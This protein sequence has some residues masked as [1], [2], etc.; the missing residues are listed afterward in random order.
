MFEYSE[1][2]HTVKLC[3]GADS[4]TVHLFGA[5]VISWVCGDQE[6]LFLSTKS[7]FD[8]SKAIRGGIPVVFP[9]FGPWECGPQHGFARIS[10][11][12]HTTKPEHN[13]NSLIFELEDNEETRKMWNFKFKLQYT[14]SLE[15]GKLFTELKVINCDKV[16]F[17][18]TTLLHT[19]F[20]IHDINECYVT[21][22]NNCK[23]SDKV[24]GQSQLTETKEKVYISENVDRVYENTS[25]HH[26]HAT[27]KI[28]YLE[29][30]STLPDT[31][32]WNPWIEKA[33]AMSD[34]NDDGYKH[35]VCVESGFV[36]NRKKLNPGE[37]FVASQ[38]VSKL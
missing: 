12:S 18:F 22:F 32:L 33:Q 5:T 28:L 37:T 15:G 30:S 26:I 2:S 31:V 23:Y 35:M 7:K 27:G 9:N 20:N 16:S 34:F 25:S 19:Y 1:S 24:S 14:V 29:K 13:E 11:W 17:D 38:T 6:Q 8:G 3:N 4:V 10:W 36:S 21:G